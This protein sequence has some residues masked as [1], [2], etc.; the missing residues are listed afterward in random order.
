MLLLARLHS[1]RLP[2]RLPEALVKLDRKPPE[3]CASVVHRDSRDGS[4][5]TVCSKQL[6]ARRVQPHSLEISRHSEVEVLSKATLQRTDSHP[7]HAAEIL[8]VDGLGIMCLN[9][10]LSQPGD[11]ISGF[12]HRT[13]LVFLGPLALV[14]WRNVDR[15]TRDLGLL[16]F[17]LSAVHTNRNCGWLLVQN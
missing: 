4:V 11:A 16:S 9:V 13:N 17:E 1:E 8:S 3:V 6:A 15:R 2:R 7:C 5:R 14:I 10:L 12:I